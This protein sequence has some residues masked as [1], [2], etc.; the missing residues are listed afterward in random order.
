MIQR[1]R[2]L[3]N[4]SEAGSSSKGVHMTSISSSPT[5]QGAVIC[6][7]PV[8]HAGLCEVGNGRRGGI[9]R[10][11][12][13]FDTH[14]LDSAS[15][16]KLC[17]ERKGKRPEKMLTYDGN[18]S[19]AAWSVFEDR[20]SDLVGPR[21]GKQAGNSGF[22]TVE[23]LHPGS[24]KRWPGRMRRSVITLGASASAS[25]SEGQ[26]KAGLASRTMQESRK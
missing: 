9:G 21:R 16:G 8:P 26:A 17:L 18:L 12:F 25:P 15:S 23:P 24:K 11:L 14:S 1:H 22:E 10:L 3:G 20:L 5:E 7:M 2:R 6:K 4:V 13:A 19:H